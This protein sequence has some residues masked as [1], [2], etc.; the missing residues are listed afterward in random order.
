[1]MATIPA[2]KPFCVTPEP[3]NHPAVTMMTSAWKIRHPIW[4][5][6]HVANLLTSFP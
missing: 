3:S 5:F 4:A 2:A 1:M 6:Y